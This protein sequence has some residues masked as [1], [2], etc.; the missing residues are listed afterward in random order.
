[1]YRFLYLTLTLI[2][3]TICAI[4]T[5]AAQSV[6]QSEERPVVEPTAAQLELNNQGVEA[7]VAKDFEQAVR[8]FRASLDLGEL[9]I[10]YV[11]MG[12]AYQY[13]NQCE[14]AEDAYA[15]ALKAPAVPRPSPEKIAAVIERYR[16]E[17]KATCVPAAKATGEDTARSEKAAKPKEAAKVAAKADRTQTIKPIEQ[18]PQVAPADDGGG[19][20]YW[21]IGSGASIAGAVALDVI[22]SSSSNG[23][24]DG[25][26]VVPA[27]LYAVG[28]GALIYGLMVLMD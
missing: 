27:G 18:P 12:R 23:R 7:I 3:S 11:N 17:L 26:D 24:F 4:P 22:P 13:A 2:L 1:M 6:R 19:A 10:T 21:L 15:R 25:L 16:E 9:N 5:A 28:T 20:A 8:L 14:K